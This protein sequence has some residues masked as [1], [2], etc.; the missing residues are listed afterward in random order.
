M[1]EETNLDE[2]DIYENYKGLTTGIDEDS[3]RGFFIGQFTNPT[4]S[5]YDNVVGFLRFNN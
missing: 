4:K 2:K 1:S 5:K 3:Q